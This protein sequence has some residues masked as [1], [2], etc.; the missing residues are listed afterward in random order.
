MRHLYEVVALE[1]ALDMPWR[2]FLG[3]EPG[4]RPV[5]SS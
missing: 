3:G 5:Q 4:R 1:R 2:R